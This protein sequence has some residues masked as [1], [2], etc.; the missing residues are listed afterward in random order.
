VA[1]ESIQ[2]FSFGLKVE[3]VVS[4]RCDRDIVSGCKPIDSVQAKLS[5]QV[6]THPWLDSERERVS[7]AKLGHVISYGVQF[8]GDPDGPT[9]YVGI[10]A[11]VV[12]L[13][14]KIL[15]AVGVGAA[16]DLLSICRDDAAKSLDS[17]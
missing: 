3:Q 10:D 17:T 13:D 7:S 9:I 2:P 16:K 5:V 4:T 1:G 11:A 12:N 14:D 15:N 6:G 8:T